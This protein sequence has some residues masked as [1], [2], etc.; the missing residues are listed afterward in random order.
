MPIIDRTTPRNNLVSDVNYSTNTAYRK[1][2]KETGRTDISFETFSKVPEVVHG[3]MFDKVVTQSYYIRI[4]KLGVLKLLKVKPV[5]KS[6]SRVDWNLYNKTGTLAYH[7][8]A[9]TQGYMFKIHLYTYGKK[10]PM[11]S[12]FHFNLAR[13]HRRS[14]AK[15]ILSNKIK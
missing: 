11:L 6:Y 3:K 7:R 9:H 5:S 4:P 15:L 13:N 2:I 1:F 12:C 8:N 14:L 10:Y